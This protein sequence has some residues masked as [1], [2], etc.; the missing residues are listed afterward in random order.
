VRLSGHFAVP[1]IDLFTDS[2]AALLPTAQAVVIDLATVELVD[3]AAVRGLGQAHQTCVEAQIWFAAVRPTHRTLPLFDVLGKGSSITEYDRL[4]QAIRVASRDVVDRACARDPIDSVELG[5]AGVAGLPA[6]H[7]VR[8]A[9]ERQA[10]EVALPVARA[11][12]ARYRRRD[13]PFE[14]LVQVASIGLIQAV[15]GFDP[16]RGSPFL[17]FAVPT[18]LGELRRYFRDRTW[19]VRVPRRMQE[20]RLEVARSTAELEQSLGRHPSVTELAAYIGTSPADINDVA[21]AA[22][23]YRPASLDAPSA[24]ER[25]Q[26]RGDQ[27]GN[28]DPGIARIEDRLA[29]ARVLAALRRQDRFLIDLR[30]NQGLTQSQIGKVLGVSQMQVSR[31]LAGVLARL[32]RALAS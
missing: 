14:D 2:I 17:A 23:G 9:A 28:F 19:A 24:T 5:L 22:T 1:S 27:I 29:L 25:S 11:L 18:I 26:S 31:N 8:V 3:A 4:D 6:N 30:F 13:E 32:R 12:A 15:H 10:I 16:L 20:M 21:L 7:R